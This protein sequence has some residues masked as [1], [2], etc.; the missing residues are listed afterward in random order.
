MFAFLFDTAMSTSGGFETTEQD[1]DFYEEL[2]IGRLK[3]GDS[4]LQ[5]W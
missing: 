5:D 2:D 1:D 3:H 4:R